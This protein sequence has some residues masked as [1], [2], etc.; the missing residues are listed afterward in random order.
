MNP[1]LVSRFGNRKYEHFE[2][3]YNGLNFEV[4][5]L[6]SDAHFPNTDQEKPC[7][8][9]KIA[10]IN[11]QMGQEVKAINYK[12]Y[13]SIMEREI[14][15][16]LKEHNKNSQWGQI[17][18]LLEDRPLRG[19]GGYDKHMANFTKF[20]QERIFKLAYSILN[21]FANDMQQINSFSE[22]CDNFGYEKD[23]F[24]AKKVFDS[25]A[26]LQAKIE[27]LKLTEKQKNFL[28]DIVATE[29]EDFNDTLHYALEEE[30]KNNEC[31]NNP[32]QNR[33]RKKYF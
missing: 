15:Q 30:K 2:F 18:G 17:K 27:S 23:S 28:I 19:W 11:V 3:D 24:K 16:I 10:V 12:F 4:K 22:F 6:D 25:Y 21:C 20:T 1:E 14:S 32:M 7:E 31:R 8:E 26:E 33:N 13:N 29:E 5:L 9:F